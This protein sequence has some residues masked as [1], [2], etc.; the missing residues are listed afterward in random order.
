VCPIRF[1]LYFRRFLNKERMAM[2]KLPDIDI[3]VAAVSVNDYLAER[4]YSVLVLVRDPRDIC[5][6]FADFF[7]AGRPREARW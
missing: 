6:S 4:D 2:K 5:L 3:K 7:K 1:D